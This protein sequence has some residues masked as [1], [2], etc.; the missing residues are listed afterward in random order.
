[1]E[2]AE[3][4]LAGMRESFGAA[5]EYLGRNAAKT[6]LAS[7]AFVTKKQGDVGPRIVA[8]LPSSG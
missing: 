5:I 3:K 1:M 6:F 2:L 8:A 4:Q 7:V